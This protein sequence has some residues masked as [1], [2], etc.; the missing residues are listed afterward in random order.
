MN[1]MENIAGASS[2][3]PLSDNGVDL[4]NQTQA[5]DF[6]EDILDDADFQIDGNA[7]ARYFWYGIVVV[8]GIAAICNVI[9]KTTLQQRY[10]GTT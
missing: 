2:E 1:S 5:M 6:L 4:S 3:I 8:I 9:Q 10:V 7:F